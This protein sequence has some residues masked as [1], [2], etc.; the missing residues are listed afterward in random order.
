MTGKLRGQNRP[1]ISKI[2]VCELDEPVARNHLRPFV[3]HGA[4]SLRKSRGGER[5]TAYDRCDHNMR[6][7]RDC[8]P[9]AREFHRWMAADRRAPPYLRRTRVPLIFWLLSALRKSGTMRSISSKYDARAGGFV[10][11]LYRIASR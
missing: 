1:A 8:R 7:A 2:L 11:E 9:V 5:F 6:N 10:C 3:L 4:G